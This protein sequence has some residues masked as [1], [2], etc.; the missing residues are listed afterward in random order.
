MPAAQC[1][2]WTA[3]PLL[4]PHRRPRKALQ[5]LLGAPQP[6]P[7]PDPLPGLVH[8]YHSVGGLRLHL[9]RTCANPGGK[10]P[11][12]LL[13]HGFPEVSKLWV[14]QPTSCR[15]ALGCGMLGASWPAVGG[16]EGSWL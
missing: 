13:L 8:E 7:L 2:C 11:V 15:P 12:L 16:S 14:G 10:K 5:L 6:P 4:A 3:A 1:A 9:V